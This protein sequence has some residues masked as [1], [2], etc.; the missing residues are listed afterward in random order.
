[1][2]KYTPAQNKANQRYQAKTFD[3]LTIRVKKGDKEKIEE[4][5][6]AAGLSLNGLMIKLLKDYGIDL[7]E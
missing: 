2:S 5:A 7:K 6:A 4:A 3:R 1:M